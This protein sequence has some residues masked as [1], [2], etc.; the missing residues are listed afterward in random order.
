MA[1]SKSDKAIQKFKKNTQICKDCG[2]C[3]TIIHC[4]GDRICI[5]CGTCFWACPSK[6]FYKVLEIS[7]HTINIIIND[8]KIKV[9]KG[10]TIKDALTRVGFKFT[11]DP[12]KEGIFAPCETGGCYSCAV[13]VDGQLKPAC[14]SGLKDG[15]IININIP[16]GIEPLRIVHGFQPHSV[17]GVGT[18]WNLKMKGIYIEVACF[19]AG[20]N[21]RCRT[22]QNFTTTYNSNILP[23]TPIQAAAQ[24]TMVRK[25]Y[26][27]DRM[28]ISGGEPTLNRKWLIKFFQDL[29]SLN[30]DPKVRL[31]L[32]T[33][34]SL[35]TKDYIDDL[36]DAGITDI[37]PDL[38]SHDL[39][40]FSR[41]IG[42]DDR[43]LVKIY[44]DRAWNAVKYISDQYYPDIVFMGVGLP[45]NK[46]F[47]RSF[48]QVHEWGVQLSQ[49]NPEIQVSVLDYRPIF[50]NHEITRPSIDEMLKVKSA[51]ESEGLKNVIVQTSKGHLK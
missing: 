29:K 39:E 18:P 16:E 46:Y 44:M 45:Y 9:P 22:C 28:A 21:F 1:M 47:Y 6:A 4:P 10:I 40:I 13:V 49:I 27:V 23:I 31:H 26:K 42:I 5:G 48:E 25:R 3:S 24:L 30:S 33:N 2:I 43:E 15:T 38:K 7:E 32:D 14:H 41:I 19:I 20:C 11:K 34:A 8:N 12:E 37:G 17:G 36:I 50:R 35:L 51:L